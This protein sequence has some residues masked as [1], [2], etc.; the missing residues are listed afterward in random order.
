MIAVVNIRGTR[1]SATV[2]N[3]A[4]AIKVGALLLIG[5]ALDRRSAAR[6]RI[7]AT[8]WP[9]ALD[10]IRARRASARR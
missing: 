9:P 8:L 5:V 2:E 7:A 6:G 3:S 10:V 4:T 1:E